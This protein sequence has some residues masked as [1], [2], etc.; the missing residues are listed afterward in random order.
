MEFKKN[1]Q[2][3]IDAYYEN[4]NG[5]RDEIRKLIF[6]Y[7]DDKV[8]TTAAMAELI[9]KG[10]ETIKS[11]RGEFNKLLNT[12]L[13]DEIVKAEEQS[14]K[15]MYPEISKPSD[16]S[17]RINNALEF[18][19]IQG[20]DINDEAAFRILKE[21][22]GDY[23]TMKLFQSAINKQTELT[24]TIGKSTFPKTFEKLNKM[25]AIFNMFGEMKEFA[26]RTFI[27]EGL[28]SEPVLVNGTPYWCP[29]PAEER[30]YPTLLN[31]ANIKKLAEM[32]EEIITEATAA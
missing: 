24:D 31:E 11:S 6:T 29:A 17:V 19:K 2:D 4:H 13:Q 26:E 30:S 12:R 22:M 25:D 28:T 1:V 3:I 16:Y 21:F 20:E 32:I 10:T 15:T 7:T 27:F 14:L 8:Y 9:R 23:E 5:M 18:I